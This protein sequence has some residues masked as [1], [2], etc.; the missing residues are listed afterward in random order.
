V[1]RRGWLRAG[2]ALALA[3]GAAAGAVAWL[4]LRDEDPVDAVATPFAATP[5]QV[6]RGAYL[7]RIG[8]CAACHTD[9]GGAPYAGGKGIATP[10]GTVYASNLTPD[11]ATGIGAWS[12]PQFWRAMH[13]GR[14]ADGRL[15]VPAF[16][17]PNFTGITRADADALFA[18]LRSQAP[19]AQPNRAH[20][21]RFPY[22]LQPALAVWRALFFTPGRDAPDPARPALWNRGAY[23]VRTLGHCSACHAPRNAF[24]ATTRSLELSGGLVPMQG[25]Y[26]PSLAS[27]AE[28]GV[29]DWPLPEIAALLKTGLTPRGA[30]LGPMSEVVSRSTQYLDDADADAM[31]AFL[32]SL[33]QT[34]PPAAASGALPDDLRARGDALYRDRCAACHGDRGQ[35]GAAAGRIAYVPL[36]GNR[37][38]LLESPVNLVRVIVHGGFPPATPGNPRPFGMPPAGQSL[39]DDDI[40]ALASYVRNAWGNAA[41]LVSAVDVRAAR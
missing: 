34:P 21:L 22:G 40:A 16:P 23:L 24:G 17:Y 25:W 28:A 1:T 19:A 11:A 10:F 4:N 27:P 9:R 8:D 30:T 35:G 20:A 7:A 33:P 12:A 26:A 2:A 41:P 15:L 38:A 18:F 32:K 37:L 6:A 29:A 31:A 5:A 13:N 36:A 39:K 14:S 3:L